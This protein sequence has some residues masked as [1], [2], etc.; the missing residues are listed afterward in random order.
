MKKG[1]DVKVRDVLENSS[2]AYSVLEFCVKDTCRGLD[3]SNLLDRPLSSV[4][5]SKINWGK[6]LDHGIGWASIYPLTTDSETDVL[7]MI[8]SILDQYKLG[9]EETGKDIVQ[10][11]KE[12]ETTITLED[13]IKV[14]KERYPEGTPYIPLS[15][16]NNASPRVSKGGISGGFSNN[17]WE[18]NVSG[19][20]YR[21]GKWAEILDK[22]ETKEETLK[23]NLEKAKKFYK[24]GVVYRSVRGF[25]GM[26][27]VTVTSNG[28]IK[29]N[30]K[31]DIWT[32]NQKGFLY[33]NG[34]WA[35][36]VNNP[37]KETKTSTKDVNL[38]IATEFYKK[39]V[40]YK[41]IRSVVSMEGSVIKSNGEIRTNN[42]GDIWTCSQ[43]G[44]IYHNGRWADVI[45]DKEVPVYG[46]PFEEIF[47]S[48]GKSFIESPN[49]PTPTTVGHKD[50]E[51][52]DV[53]L[54]KIRKS[55]LK[56]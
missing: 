51:M 49:T 41:P 28:E 40:V 34:K 47:K 22:K 32:Y 9:K 20:I 24:K 38:E 56:Y 8:S 25:S 21:N 29:S 50:M 27:G 6:C 48:S 7:T 10:G 35:D 36:I 5:F 2:V 3:M 23:K 39:G 13:L 46:N 43:K 54:K 19:Y 18:V 52:S 53:K 42:R 31:G 14:A 1:I 11:V 44:Y 15:F 30:N 26:E 33:S 45:T 12:P 55:K 17:V 4:I 37:E 16:G